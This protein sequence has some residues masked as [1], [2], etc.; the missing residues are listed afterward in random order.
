MY[1][2]SNAVYTYEDYERMMRLED[3]LI[4]F[5]MPV[6]RE[7]IDEDPSRF[8]L[9]LLSGEVPSKKYEFVRLSIV[10]DGGTILYNDKFLS[11]VPKDKILVVGY[12][13][14]REK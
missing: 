7:E 14:E 6:Y 11:R 13:L 10:E 8:L 2:S 3:M 1:I 5:L 12:A 9:I 4:D